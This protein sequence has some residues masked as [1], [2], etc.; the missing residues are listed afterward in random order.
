MAR[1]SSPILL[2]AAILLAAPSLGACN[3][4]LTCTSDV[5]AG[6]GMFHGV[7]SGT[8]AEAELR[9]TSLLVACGQLCASGGSAGAEGCVGRCAVD[10]ES[11][12]IGARTSCKKGGSR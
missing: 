7:A 9:R 3:R 5:T 11:A 2:A 1:S 10:V 4:E 8:V 12:K 6:S